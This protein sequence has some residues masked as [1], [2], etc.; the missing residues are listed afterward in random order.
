MLLV[1]SVRMR[2][3]VN[4]RRGEQELTSNINR[5]VIA[6]WTGRDAIALERHIGELEA[7][8]VS[9]PSST[10]IFYFVSTNRLVT[11][12]VIE[13]S[14]DR[15][16]GEVE[17]VLVQAG[18][19][20]YVGAGSDHT[21]RAAEAFSVTV[22][23]QMCD[24]P[25]ASELWDFADVEA[26]WDSL[27]LRS[28]VFVGEHRVLYQEGSVA[29]IR[30]PA[31]LIERYAGTRDLPDGTVMFCGTFAAKGGIRS[32]RR[33]EFELEDPVRG[34]QIRHGYDV[35]SLPVVM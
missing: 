7:L 8:G 4:G 2:F 13:V 1:W 31:D 25:L 23:K 32:A 27:V 20:L 5:V 22:S 11:A 17:F 10:P 14:G 12:P 29:D 26:H 30:A 18:K 34:R 24:K 33:F 3:T 16:S 35:V 9:R 21:D 19:R 6:G 28:W 15:S